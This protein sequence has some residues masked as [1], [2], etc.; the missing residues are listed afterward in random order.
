M[1]SNKVNQNTFLSPR[2]N[3]ILGSDEDGSENDQQ[4]STK[5][6]LYKRKAK[7]T[8]NSRY[9]DENFLVDYSGNRNK[10]AKFGEFDLRM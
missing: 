10:Q 2:N 3:S 7:D 9:P 6:T 5:R 1:S 4:I 8:K